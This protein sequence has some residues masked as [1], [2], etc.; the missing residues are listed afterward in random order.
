MDKIIL[1]LVD[2]E[3]EALMRVTGLIRKKGGTMKKICMEETSD[4]SYAKLTIT[5]GYAG[6]ME[7]IISQI[8][9]FINVHTVEEIFEATNV[10]AVAN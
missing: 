2:N 10:K 1:A 8:E 4:A 6:E 5:I 7:Q 9:K 3:P